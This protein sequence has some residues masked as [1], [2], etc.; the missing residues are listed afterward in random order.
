[1]TSTP[2]K[3]KPDAVAEALC[4]VRFECKESAD[5]PELVIGRLTDFDKWE[6]L[7]RRRLPASDIPLALRNAD[8]NLKHQP[9]IELIE[10]DG[11]RRVKLG[12]NAASFHRFAPYVGWEAFKPELDEMIDFLFSSFSDVKTTRIGFRYIDTFTKEEHGVSGISD[13]DLNVFISGEEI[14]SS[15]NINYVKRPA[16]GHLIT[17]RVASPDLVNAPSKPNL[18]AMVDIDVYTPPADQ[19]SDSG[20]VKDWVDAAHTYMKYEFFKLFTDDMMKRLVEE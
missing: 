3:L 1:M 20:E 13:L 14:T 5:A 10:K 9:S 17:I 11:P 6:G 2:K 16:P 19:M 18:A 15:V 8:P 12:S 7:E 4:E